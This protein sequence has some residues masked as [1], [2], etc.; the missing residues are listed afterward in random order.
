MNARGRFDD[1]PADGIYKG[2]VRRSFSSVHTTVTSYTFAPGAR[3]PL[4]THPQEQITLMQEGEAEMTIGDQVESLS[5]GDWTVVAA[6]AE[7]GVRA[8]PNGASF[9]AIVAP[10]RESSDAYTVFESGGKG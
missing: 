3:F 7:H 4:H 5:P 2:V 8:G 6:E 1:L 10:R 9:L